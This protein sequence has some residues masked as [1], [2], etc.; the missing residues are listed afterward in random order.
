MLGSVDLSAA[1]LLEDRPI[2][3]FLRER[4]QINGGVLSGDS[5]DY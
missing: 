1:T 3:G 5:R 4:K 2:S